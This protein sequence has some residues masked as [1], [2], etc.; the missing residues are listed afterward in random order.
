[1]ATDTAHRT[2]GMRAPVNKRQEAPETAR[3]YT[4]A[5]GLGT[6]NHTPT[7][8]CTGATKPTRCVKSRGRTP[9]PLVRAWA[10]SGTM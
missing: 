8:H 4:P 6:T 2:H 1:M 5:E 7:V 10:A 9:R 3:A